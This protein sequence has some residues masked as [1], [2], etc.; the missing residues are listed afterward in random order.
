MLKG[1]TIDWHRN[2][3]RTYLRVLRPQFHSLGRILDREVYAGR[4]DVEGV[5]RVGHGGGD[6]VQVDGGVPV[7]PL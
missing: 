7:H 3:D 6:E 1:F 5:V 4:G 2:D